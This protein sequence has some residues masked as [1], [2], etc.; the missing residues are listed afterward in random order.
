[1]ESDTIFQDR[2][3][4]FDNCHG[5]IAIA[6]H[7]GGIADDVGKHNGGETGGGHGDVEIKIS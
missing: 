4:F 7:H 3:K 2:L 6:L 1:M 5:R